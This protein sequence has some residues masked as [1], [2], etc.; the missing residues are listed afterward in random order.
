MIRNHYIYLLYDINNPNR[1]YSHLNIV[2]RKIGSTCNINMR[3]KP[4][5]IENSD[6]INKIQFNVTVNYVYTNN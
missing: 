1:Y 5:L 2:G 3:M 4:Y 6:K